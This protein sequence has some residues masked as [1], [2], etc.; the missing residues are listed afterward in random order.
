MRELCAWYAL[1]VKHQ[2]EMAARSAL[3]FK[4]FEALVPTYRARRR[5]SDRVK[6]ID[7]PVFAGDVLC[8]FLWQ[9]L[10]GWRG[11][12]KV[13]AQ[14]WAQGESPGVNLPVQAMGPADLL[15]VSVYGAPEFTRTVRVSPEGLIRLPMLRER[16]DA[17]GLMPADVETPLAAALAEPQNLV[18]PTGN[19]TIAEYHNPPINVLCAA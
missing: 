18:G 3:E 5:W 15:A 14:W 16:I 1:T 9:E 2:H 8:R 19:V 10:V 7:L 17:R 6:E 11:L 4:G 12:A 13:E